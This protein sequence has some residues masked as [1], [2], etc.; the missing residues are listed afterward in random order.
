MQIQTYKM[1]EL[2]FKN[3]LYPKSFKKARVNFSEFLKA[4]EPTLPLDTWMIKVSENNTPEELIAK[5]FASPEIRTLLDNQLP[6]NKYVDVIEE[7]PTALEHLDSDFDIVFLTHLFTTESSRQI[8]VIRSVLARLFNSHKFLER[9][10]FAKTFYD[11]KPRQIKIFE[12]FE[13]RKILTNLDIV[14]KVYLY[15]TDDQMRMTL[16]DPHVTKR[17]SEEALKRSEEPWHEYYKWT[18]LWLNLFNQEFYE[19]FISKKI[20]QAIDSENQLDELIQ[21]ICFYSDLPNSRVKEK[22]FQQKHKF[23]GNQQL[24]KTKWL[25]V[26]FL[27]RHEEILLPYFKNDIIL[28]LIKK[29]PS[30]KKLPKAFLLYNSKFICDLLELLDNNEDKIK[31]LDKLDPGQQLSPEFGYKNNFLFFLHCYNKYFE[32][33]HEKYVKELRYDTIYHPHLKYEEKSVLKTMESFATYFRALDAYDFQSD[34]QLE[35]DCNSDDFELS[36]EAQCFR[37]RK[38]PIPPG[39]SKHYF[40]Y[41]VCVERYFDIHYSCFYNLTFE[42]KS[43]KKFLKLVKDFFDAK[44]SNNAQCLF[45]FAAY[46]KEKTLLR[47]ICLAYGEQTKDFYKGMNETTPFPDLINP[48]DYEKFRKYL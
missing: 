5:I 22:I 38:F 31:L 28:S 32:Y 12:D 6:K 11:K 42:K 4:S 35:Q 1:T 33:S 2:E 39:E 20:L 29:Y 30:F 24:E 46:K 27:K 10:N 17:L 9:K 23:K 48:K 37:D 41:Q 7:Y 47:Q 44:P 45:L 19:Q 21:V 16:E 3:I 25:E 34:R 14:K 8:A 15:F 26:L 36:F 43:K 13:F 18:N 40:F